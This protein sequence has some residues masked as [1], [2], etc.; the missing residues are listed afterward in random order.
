MDWRHQCNRLHLKEMK[1][2]KQRIIVNNLP[3][4]TV[5]F[6]IMKICATTMGETAGNLLAQAMKVGYA[7]SSAILLSFFYNTQ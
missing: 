1:M 7:I 6:W 5:S 2:A 3:I 4:I